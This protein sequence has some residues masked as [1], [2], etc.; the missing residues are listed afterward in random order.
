MLMRGSE[1]SAQGG[2]TRFAFTVVAYEYGVVILPRLIQQA[3]AY[4][5]LYD[6]A[7]NTASAQISH[8]GVAV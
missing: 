1:G 7:V 6:A 3:V 2:V 5:I 8:H 4:V